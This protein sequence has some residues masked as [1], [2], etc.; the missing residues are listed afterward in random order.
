MTEVAPH[1]LPAAGGRPESVSAVTLAVAEMARSVAFYEALGFECAAGGA[2]AVFTTMRVGAVSLNLQF[3]PSRVADGPVWGRVIIW[4]DDVDAMYRRVVAA[5][6]C[7][8]ATPQDASWGER[9]FHVRDPDG[10][11]LSFA[12][13]LPAPPHGIGTGRARRAARQLVDVIDDDG[14]VVGTATRAQVRAGNLR[15]RSVFVAVVSPTPG[16]APLGAPSADCVAVHQRAAWKDLWPSWWD[17]AFGGVVAAGED[18]DGA[19]RRELVEEAGIDVDAEG[20]EL[21]LLTEGSFDTDGCRE[22]GRV[23]LVRHG[24]PV[25]C[26]DGEVART[27]WVPRAELSRWAAERRLVPDSAALVVPQLRGLDVPRR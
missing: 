4:V 10:H 9:Y 24:G 1:A 13:P 25:V 21:E 26:R 6:I 20:L 14:R 7:P 11:E 27:G 2:D 3:E 15:H 17:V 18:W 12:R 23:Y 16:G 22:L 19:A 8:D 5:D